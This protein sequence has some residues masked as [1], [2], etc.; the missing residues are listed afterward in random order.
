VVSLDTRV[1]I[2]FDF[3]NTAITLVSYVIITCN[4]GSVG[5]AP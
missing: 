4:A 3:L 2:E 5:V 1:S